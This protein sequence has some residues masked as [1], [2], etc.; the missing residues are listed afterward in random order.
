MRSLGYGYFKMIAVERS[1][2]F[3]EYKPMFIEQLPI[4]KPTLGRVDMLNHLVESLLL[5]YSYEAELDIKQKVHN[6]FN[7]PEEEITCIE[8]FRRD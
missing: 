3:F 2:G 4:P 6:I 5:N 1:G 8:N 7:L